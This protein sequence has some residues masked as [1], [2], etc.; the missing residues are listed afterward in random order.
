VRTFGSGPITHQLVFLAGDVGNFH[1]VSGWGQVF[2]LLAGEDVKRGQMDFCVTVL[3]SLGGGH[4]DDL[5]RATLDDNEAILS[6][7]RT[8]HWV[9]C[10]GASISAVEGVL[11]LQSQVSSYLEAL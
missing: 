11:M 4:F 9:G 5:A 10:R 8:L 3:A 6:Q 2:E 1:I 7:G